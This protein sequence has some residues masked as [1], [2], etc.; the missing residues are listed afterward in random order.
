M[1]KFL[2]ALLILIAG[3]LLADDINLFNAVRARPSA[4][5]G[6]MY[7][8]AGTSG[9]IL[10]LPIG[11][12][13][14]CL[15]VTIGFPAWG[16]CGGGGGSSP[17]TTKGDLWGFST[18]DA[19]VPVGADGTF[20]TGDSGAA[21]GVSWRLLL[22]AD[23]PAIPESGVTGLV[24]DLAAK[25]SLQSSTPG[26]AQTGHINVTGTVI[27]GAFSG[28]LTGNVTGN[29]S[30]ATALAANG[31]NCTG[32]DF[33]KGVD[34]SGNSEGC[35]TPAGSGGT[36]TSVATT[37]PITG[38]T[39]TGTGTI[40]CPTCVAS[41]AAL[42]ANELVAGDGLQ[43]SKTTTLSYDT[44]G[45]LGIGATAL[46]GVRL[47]L[48]DTGNSPQ[49]RVEGDHT[50]VGNGPD[51]ELI[52]TGTGARTWGLSAT[53]AS[54]TNPLAA[55]GNFGI[56]DK[57][58]G[59]VPFEL[60]TSGY[61]R[62]LGVKLIGSTSGFFGIQAGATP[63]ST[64]YKMPNTAPSGSSTFLS[65]PAP[66]IGFSACSFAAAPG[67]GGTTSATFIPYTSTAST[68]SDTTMGWDATTK[69]LTS[70][71]GGVTL[72]GS[73][74]GGPTFKSPAIGGSAVFVA[75]ASDGTANQSIVT[76]GAGNLTFATVAGSGG[77]PLPGTI[78]S[79]TWM[80]QGTNTISTANGGEEMTIPNLNNV[81]GQ[82]MRYIAVPGSTPW[83]ITIA[84]ER[85]S[86]TFNVPFYGSGIYISDGTKYKMMISPHSD[87]AVHIFNFTNAT[88]YSSDAVG[89]TAYTTFV[90]QCGGAP[91][92]MKIVNDGTNRKW[93]LSADGVRF[94]LFL[95]EGATTFLTET[96]VG[97]GGYYNA[98]GA[99]GTY[100]G[101]VRLIYWKQGTS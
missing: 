36:V 29:A 5:A 89:A 13:G 27:A 66:T 96:R 30:T 70:G 79:L 35:A 26:S 58:A 10:R 56:R 4:T 101:Y 31:T 1:R 42:T 72:A 38:G 43:A 37:S 63:D 41:A 50:G 97:Y 24:A 73:T 52:A 18:V 6:D 48:K 51:I 69:I 46:S 87:N 83:S 15:K 92:F 61:A 11:S 99:G 62:F 60:D 16:T 76:D 47:Y 57:T 85:V 74:S 53:S 21:L 8:T 64:I 17:L 100:T 19:R 28:P 34:A 32:A 14:Q 91:K 88:T 54:G 84:I 20:L 82:S 12:S 2:A 67:V 75:P 59:T 9:V 33:A 39:I 68:L 71:T 22:A 81:Y 40:A 77:G 25:V 23:I 95:S 49:F 45:N 86:D 98:N 93:Y 65:C 94:Q 90:S 7:Y 80:N 55:S 44:N 78:P 3:P